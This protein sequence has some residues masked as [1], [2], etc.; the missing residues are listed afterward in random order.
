MDIAL[1]LGILGAFGALAAMLTLEGQ[2]LTAVLLPAPMIMVLGATIAVSFA[3]GT[4]GDSV[5][6]MRS[7]P[8]AFR[9]KTGKPA[10]AIEQLVGIAEKARRDGLLSLE[11]DAAEAEDPFLKLA[12]QNLADGVGE[13]ELRTLLEEQVAAQER[14]GKAAAKWFKTAGGYA[15]TIGII[16]TVVSLTHVLSNLSSPQH[17]GPLIAS[18]FIATLWGLLSANF[19]WLPI[20]DRLDR[21]TD[22]ESERM[23][24]VLEA[25]LAIQAGA[26]PRLLSERLTAMVPAAHRPKPEKEPQPQ[27]DE[28]D[29]AA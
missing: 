23:Q 8:A 3:S 25:V 4:V 27:D 19:L 13:E 15:P 12:L 21:L 28:F 11:T 14:Q 2:H 17:L 26:G 1:I 24:L 5:R 22:I 16:G 20:G 6:A 9:G 29:D 7:I 18:A 10:E